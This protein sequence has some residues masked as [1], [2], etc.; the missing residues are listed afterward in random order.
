M[1]NDLDHVSYWSLGFRHWALDFGNKA[2]FL[3]VLAPLHR[4]ADRF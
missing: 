2:R 4:L 3:W 1:T